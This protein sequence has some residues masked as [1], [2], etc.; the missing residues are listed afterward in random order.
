MTR[1]GG[2]TLIEM[3]VAVVLLGLVG[4]AIYQLLVNNQRLYREQTERVE[5]T[6]NARAAISML[7]AEIRELDAGD[8]A[9]GD[10][11]A[12]TSSSLTYKAMRSLYVLCQPP[13]PAAGR[14]VLDNTFF[15][16]LRRVDPAQDSVLVLAENDPGTRTDDAWIHA[17]VT[18]ATAGLACPGGGASLELQLAG[19]DTSAL[20][21]VSAGAPLRTFEVAEVRLYT[22]GSGAQ[23]VGG[24]LYQKTAGAW[25]TTQPIVGPMTTRG[26]ELTYYDAAGAVTTVPALVARVGITVQSR[27]A[28]AVPTLQGYVTQVALRN[29]PNY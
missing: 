22:D 4:T 12:M 7:P 26:L 1:R 18:S 8:P 17:D 29:N 3:L 25:A 16:G 20:A 28:G 2:F 24:R 6:G 14:V 9:G 10:V 11:L 13:D 27:S 5:V 21:G 19:L 23:W 15:Y